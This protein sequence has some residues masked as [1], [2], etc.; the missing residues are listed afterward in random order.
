VSSTEGC[1]GI[2]KG[3]AVEEVDGGHEWLVVIGWESLEVNVKGQKSE[4]FAKSPKLHAKTELHHVTFQAIE[5]PD[6]G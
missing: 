6:L 2:A 1:L 3:P 5:E 4:A